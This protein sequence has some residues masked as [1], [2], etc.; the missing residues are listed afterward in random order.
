MD[1]C[2]YYEYELAL[3]KAM[4]FV[5]TTCTL[6]EEPDN[7]LH[8]KMIFGDMCIKVLVTFGLASQR[9]MGRARRDALS[10]LLQLIHGC[11][12]NLKIMI[13]ALQSISGQFTD[14]LSECSDHQTQIYYT[15]IMYRLHKY[16]RK[17]AKEC[18]K[19]K[20]FLE[21]DFGEFEKKF[22]TKKFDSAQSM[23]KASLAILAAFNQKSNKWIKC[24]K[25]RCIVMSS[26]EEG[27]NEYLHSKKSSKAIA[28]N[29]ALLYF[30]QEFLTFQIDTEDGKETLDVP[31]RSKTKLDDAKAQ[32][33]VMTS[34]NPRQINPSLEFEDGMVICIVGGKSAVQKMHQVFTSAHTV[35]PGEKESDFS[36]C[37]IPSHF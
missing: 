7:I 11:E 33:Y 3:R 1:S 4:E 27:C 26:S 19:C 16:S 5:F 21:Q 14:F 10:T 22:F 15:N 8:T 23:E 25:V 6:E 29:Q 9:G 20:A 35:G 28:Q 24:N 30:G 31:L 2:N 34:L 32:L 36:F 17:N 18:T 37:S 13:G 12:T